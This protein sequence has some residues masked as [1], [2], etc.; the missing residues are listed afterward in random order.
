MVNWGKW[1][2]I[3][4]PEPPITNYSYALNTTMS[5]YLKSGVMYTF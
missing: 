3:A 5:K 4:V 1:G 2:K